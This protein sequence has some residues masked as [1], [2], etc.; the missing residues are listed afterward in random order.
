LR[1]L[2]MAACP[3]PIMMTHKGRKRG[4]SPNIG[5]Q[6]QFDEGLTAGRGLVF[7]PPVARNSRSVIR[8]ACLRRTNPAGADLASPAAFETG[9]HAR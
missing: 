5:I 6:P 1:K 2:N 3:Y 8:T 7:Q 4:T 9:S